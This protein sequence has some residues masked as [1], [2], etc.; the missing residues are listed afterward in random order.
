M[1][2]RELELRREHCARMGHDYEHPPKHT[3]KR[4]AHCRRCG[5]WLSFSE[6]IDYNIGLGLLGFMFGGLGASDIG[7]FTAADIRKIE[8]GR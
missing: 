6:E 1:T 4:F 2:E 5:I 7:D 8:E 3:L